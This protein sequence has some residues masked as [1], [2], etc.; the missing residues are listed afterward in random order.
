VL[1][2]L[3][4]KSLLITAYFTN[5]KEDNSNKRRYTSQSAIVI[6]MDW[7]DDVMY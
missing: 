6:V 1:L 4:Y 2:A 5:F 7:L 3:R